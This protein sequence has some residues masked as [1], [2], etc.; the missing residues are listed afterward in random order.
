MDL[1]LA[2]KATVVTGASKGI[3]LAIVRALAAESAQVTAGARH[4]A[5]MPDGVRTVEADLGTPDGPARLIADAAA[6]YGRLDLLVNNVG[7][8][9]PR[10]GGFLSITDDE[11]LA[12]LTI[13]LMSAVRATRAALPHLLASRGTI[14]TVVSV[15]APLPDPLVMDYSAAKAAL[16]SFN[17]SLSKEVGPQ[18]V[19][20]VT[21]S[22]GP[23][24]TDLWLGSD[25]VAATVGG[26]VGLDPADV[27]KKAA[28]DAATG[29]F[30]TPE[31]V[32][33]LVVMAASDR[34]G[35]VTGTDFIIDGGLVS[36][37]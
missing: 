11:W 36:T 32:A 20:V 24:S 8:A 5:E 4:F 9:H 10:T 28:G 2:D 6:A 21:V 27:Q 29:R 13:N 30:S 1:N 35:N 23:V 31:E 7:A 22:P 3:G 15:N 25:G 12:T 19:R 26:A 17:K 16:A 37:L 34:I 14:V 18:G 33:A